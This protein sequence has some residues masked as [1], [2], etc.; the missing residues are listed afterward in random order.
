M[1][2]AGFQL[3]AREQSGVRAGD[4]RSDSETIDTV[5]G[6]GQTY[7]QHNS[8]ARPAG[9][10]VVRWNFTWRAPNKRTDIVFDLAANA[11]N[12]DRSALGDFVFTLSL[13]VPARQ[14]Q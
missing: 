5:S 11:A 2:S 6:D 10:S 8:A 1:L 9:R 12:D 4:F 7:L 3:A 13:T 14:G